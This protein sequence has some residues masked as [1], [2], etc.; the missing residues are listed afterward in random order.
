MENYYILI[1]Q[2]L[3]TSN[4]IFDVVLDM[5][6]NLNICNN[7]LKI[8]ILKIL[9]KVIVGVLVLIIE[10][11]VML[12]GIVNG[13]MAIVTSINFDDSK[14]ISNITIKILNARFELILN[15]QN[16][17]KK[18]EFFFKVYQNLVTVSP[19]LIFLT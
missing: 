3:F 18:C 5:N 14:N 10:N 4:E 15:R 19:F 2:K 7:G 1:F 11:I 6:L 8:P 12:R 9:K 13:T 16:Y 17:K